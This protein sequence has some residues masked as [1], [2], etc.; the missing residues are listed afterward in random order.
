MNRRHFLGAVGSATI[1]S[2][3]RRLWALQPRHVVIAGAG[4]IG[5][6]IGYHLAKRGV[7]VSI[8]EKQRPGSGATGDSFAYLNASTKQPRSYYDLNLF[9]IE[10]WRRLELELG[11]QLPIQW[12]GAVYW[13]SGKE[14]A[15][16]LLATLRTYQQWGYAGH[17]VDEA[18]IKRLLPHVFSGP[19]TA[20]V[21]YEQEGTLD[22]LIAVNA[23]LQRAQALGAK[24]QFPTEVTGLGVADGR[25]RVVRTTQ[26]DIEADVFVIAAGTGSQQLASLA[27]VNLPLVESPGVLAHSKAQGAL[28][29]RVAFSPTM[30][31]KQL[32]DG[33]IV[34]SGSYEG[35]NFKSNAKTEGEQILKDVSAF[36]PSAGGIALD[37][38][39]IGH[40]VMPS[41]GFPIVGFADG[42]RNL[43]V[44]AT[45]SGITLAPI[46]GQLA[47][48]EI[49]DGVTADLLSPYRPSRFE[50]TGAP[51]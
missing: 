6:S 49:L 43:Y 37:W 35:S 22:P 15:E 29:D 12:G 50:K 25:V 39:S 26:W 36:L 40:R 33:R 41:D 1:A 20:G 27:G 7:R 51:N 23:L 8:L 34:A 14:R 13:R 3:S 42:H 21:F 16:K 28:L 32:P 24:V 2:Q 18:E 5:A 9:G 17:D 31:F 44:A 48:Q 46:I 47:S 45:H 19:V 11:D 30:S 10:G 38:V 4:I